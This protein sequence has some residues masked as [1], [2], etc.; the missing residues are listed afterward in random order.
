MQM[1]VVNHMNTAMAQI[2]VCISPH[3]AKVFVLLTRSSAQSIYPLII[4]ILIALDRTH[5][6]RVFMV[7]TV[8][9]PPV[10]QNSHREP[11]AIRVDI[12]H[13]SGLDMSE[14][15]DVDTDSHTSTSS[16]KEKR[17]EKEHHE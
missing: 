14:F 9:R 13:G 6:D 12:E 2:T 5:C 8:P 11:V 16:R 3:C 7:S 17:Q 15:G 1:Q 10:S 4:F